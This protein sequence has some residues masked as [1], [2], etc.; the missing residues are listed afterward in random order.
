M[1]SG[2]SGLIKGNTAMDA[3]TQHET[4]ILT[5]NDSANTTSRQITLRQATYPPLP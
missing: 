3:Q 5:G 2:G 1:V 4:I